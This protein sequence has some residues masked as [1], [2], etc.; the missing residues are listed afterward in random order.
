[1]QTMS[2]LPWSRPLIF[3]LRVGM[4]YTIGWR[5]NRYKAVRRIFAI[6]VYIMAVLGMVFSWYID[7]RGKMYRNDPIRE[8]VDFM[9]SVAHVLQGWCSAI[10]VVILTSK[11]VA[12]AKV[13]NELLRFWLR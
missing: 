11:R 9:I 8:E 3:L 10:S 13:F 2:A 12:L 1:M 4:S 6:L 5:A 7:H